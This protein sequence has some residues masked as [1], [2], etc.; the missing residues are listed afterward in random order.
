MRD[1]EFAVGSDCRLA[2]LRVESRFTIH[3]SRF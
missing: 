2:A 1:E 3:E